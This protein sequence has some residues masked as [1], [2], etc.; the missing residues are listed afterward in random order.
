MLSRLKEMVSHIMTCIDNNDASATMQGIYKFA[1]LL[2]E[3]ML[4]NKG[5]IF[6]QEIVNLNLCLNLMVLR[7]EQNDLQ[8]L[9]DVLAAGFADYL[10]EWDFSNKLLN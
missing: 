9:K 2:D 7:M 8:G 6:E 3:F 4:M 10:K 5:Y 1:L